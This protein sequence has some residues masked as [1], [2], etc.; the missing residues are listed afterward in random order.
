[1]EVNTVPKTASAAAAPKVEVPK[2]AAKPAVHR[3]VEAAD[4]VVTVPPAGAENTRASL[5]VDEST[6]RII[7]RIINRDTGEV[8][9]Q[10]PSEEMLQIYRAARKNPTSSLNVKI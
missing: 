8:V 10:T 2:A 5:S 9:R 3:R 6:G 4:P 1:M 7:G